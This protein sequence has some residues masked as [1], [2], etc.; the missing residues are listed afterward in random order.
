[1]KRICGLAIALA[2]LSGARAPAQSMTFDFEDG[3]DQGWGTA[4]GDGPD[5]NNDS[6]ASHPI[7]NIGG[8][9]RMQLAV[10]SFQTASVRSNGN[11]YLAAINAAFANPAVSTISYDWYV[12]TAGFTGATF[13][14]LGTY[15]NSGQAPFSYSQDFDNAANRAVL[16][17]TDLASGQVFSGTNSRTVSARYGVLAADFLNA[18]FQ[19]FGLIVNGNGTGADTTPVKVYF[20]NIK[21]TAVPEPT[22]LA[23]LGLAIPALGA[24]AGKRRK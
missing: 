17:G 2:L 7:V 19:R 20:D 23:L 11:P 24:L 6:T 15:V 22:A 9:N 16:S 8:S 14:E 3:T 21:I 12:D 5:G 4:F 18:P 1:M 10:G 13:L